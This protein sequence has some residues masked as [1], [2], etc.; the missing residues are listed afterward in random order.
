MPPKVVVMINIRNLWVLLALLTMTLMLTTTPTL[1]SALAVKNSNSSISSSS[2]S[3]LTKTASTAQHIKGVKVLRVHTVPSKVVVG[4]AFSIRGTIVN[5]STS[6]ITFT[7]GTCTPPLSVNFDKNAV[8]EPQTTGAS[9]KAKQVTLEPG[10]HSY[11][12]NSPLSGIIYRAT[13]PGITNA[14]LTFT[15]KVTGPTNKPLGDSISR[16]YTFNIL[17]SGASPTSTLTSTPS[18]S[19]T[20]RTPLLPPTT[21]SQPGVLKVVP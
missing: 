20:S 1:E 19:T 12:L 13:S 3:T 10:G 15:Y 7:N 16:V 17:S 14:T 6:T 8:S 9:C 5:N 18:H 4:S 2:S 21:N 11:I